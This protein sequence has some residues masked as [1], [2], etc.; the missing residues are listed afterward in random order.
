MPLSPDP[1]LIGPPTGGAWL[2]D[3]SGAHAALF[4]ALAEPRRRQILSHV[5]G[6]RV[7]TGVLC[8]RLGC[9]RLLLRY[10]LEVLAAAGLV[11]LRGEGAE[12]RIEGLQALS[13]YFDLALVGLA[14]TEARRS[15][16]G[17]AGGRRL[18]AGRATP[19]ALGVIDP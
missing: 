5:V 1:P 2:S 8:R 11:E 13:R 4:R 14:R 19:H 9:S 16:E 3:L 18:V 6:G 7:G 10:H 17:R 15:S 12:A